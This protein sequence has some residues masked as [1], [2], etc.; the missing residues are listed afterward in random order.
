MYPKFEYF[1]E[2]DVDLFYDM[3]E[4]FQKLHLPGTCRKKSFTFNCHSICRALVMFYGNETLQLRDGYISEIVM[5]PRKKEKM[6]GMGIHSWL[7]TNSGS[8]LDPYPIG[9]Y[10]VF[11][12]F[13]ANGGDEA[14]LI[15][16]R[17]VEYPSV[18][19]DAEF[20]NATN[21]EAQARYQVSRLE[22]ATGRTRTST[23]W[24]S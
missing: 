16:A 22:Q 9:I 21:I 4:T 11:P 23:T 14:E 24:I 17:Y 2:E 20:F 18:T 10:S 7:T 5:H 12:L 8:I 3:C 13:I 6:H 19:N 15:K 1:N